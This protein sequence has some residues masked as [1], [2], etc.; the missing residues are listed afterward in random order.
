MASEVSKK[1]QRY[2]D[3]INQICTYLEEFLNRDEVPRENYIKDEVKSIDSFRSLK[4]EIALPEIPSGEGY[5][6]LIEED[7]VRADDVLP[8]AVLIQLL[9]Q[10]MDDQKILDRLLTY[11]RE[12]GPSAIQPA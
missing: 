12:D 6:M 2:L 3:G 5:F 10:S 4:I 11:G 1:R 9:P 8:E 7:Y